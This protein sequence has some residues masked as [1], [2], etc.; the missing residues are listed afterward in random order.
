MVVNNSI[1]S[2]HFNFSLEGPSKA[3]QIVSTSSRIARNTSTVNIPAGAIVTAYNSFF[4]GTWNNAG[5]IYLRN[6]FIE[7]PTGVDLNIDQQKSSQIKNSSTV[8]G[9]SVTDALNTLSGQ[10]I[11][12]A[13]T[14]VEGINITNQA[15]N[16]TIVVPQGKYNPGTLALYVN[17]SKQTRT[18]VGQESSGNFIETDPSTGTATWTGTPPISGTDVITTSYHY[19]P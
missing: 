6:S 3:F 4:R 11:S 12:S 10:I 9:N 5:V 15:G 13:P 14:I 2:G 19:N 17:G 7:I 18:I 8:T 1:I 16:A